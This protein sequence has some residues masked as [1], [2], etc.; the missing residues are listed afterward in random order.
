MMKR[1]SNIRLRAVK[2]DKN[3]LVLEA[4]SPIGYSMRLRNFGP[5][6]TVRGANKGMREYA[7]IV[8]YSEEQID[9]VE[10]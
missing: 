5:Y 10:E 3:L 9:F 1:K 2:N 8:G 7:R 6:K 4:Y